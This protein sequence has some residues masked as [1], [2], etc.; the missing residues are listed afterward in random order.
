MLLSFRRRFCAVNPVHG[1]PENELKERDL[2]SHAQSCS[3]VLDRR[4]TPTLR[5]MNEQC[6]VSR[7]R[8][9]PHAPLK[10][11]S[12]HDAMDVRT[13]SV[14]RA[15]TVH[16]REKRRHDVQGMAPSRSLAR[17][18]EAKETLL[19]RVCRMTWNSVCKWSMVLAVVECYVISLLIL[20]LLYMFREGIA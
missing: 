20:L 11:G 13:C 1:P 14:A 3:L 18:T 15:A 9:P 4:T 17:Y 6:V 19:F 8:R 5:A 7:R 16:E 10:S 2:L 12:E